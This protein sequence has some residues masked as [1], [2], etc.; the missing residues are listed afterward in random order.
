MYLSINTNLLGLFYPHTYVA[1][2]KPNTTSSG[3]TT[4]YKAC[5]KVPY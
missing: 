4:T 3:T 1:Y 5:L 2:Y